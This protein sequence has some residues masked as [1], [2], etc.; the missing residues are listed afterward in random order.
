MNVRYSE[1]YKKSGEAVFERPYRLKMNDKATLDAKGV[2]YGGD[3]AYPDV[4]PYN[5][6]DKPPASQR[7]Y[8]G[9][10]ALTCYEA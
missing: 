4:A 2:N 3:N 7:G 6:T 9:S 5:F 10:A 1:G 8:G